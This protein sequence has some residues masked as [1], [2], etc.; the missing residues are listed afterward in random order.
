MGLNA[1]RFI[2]VVALLLVFSSSIFVMVNDI[3][4]VNHFMAAKQ[5]G[6]A[7][8][9]NCDYIENS[10]VPNQAAGVF[11]AILNRLL[12]ILE[13]ITLLLAELPPAF[14]QTFFISY[15]PVLGPAFGLGALGI[16]QGLIGATILSHHVDDFTLVAAFF[17]FSVGCLNMFLGLIFRE[18]AKEKRSIR[19]WKGEKKSVLPTSLDQRPQFQN[20]PS[21]VHSVFSEKTLA[22]SDP[23]IFERSNSRGEGY[24]FGRQGE[25]AAGL[26]GFLISKPLESLPRY[27]AR[28]SS[29]HSAH[30][31]DGGSGDEEVYAPPRSKPGSRSHSR[32]GS[33]SSAGSSHYSQP[34]SRAVTPIPT[35]HSSPTAI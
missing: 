12:I 31:S 22:P 28:P 19:V 11:W 13:V 27:A 34:P 32:S 29:N 10:T 14:M 35:F 6:N 33:S 24:G 30:R 20:S 4:A 25:K 17:L 18:K 1:V 26:K 7:T 2:S 15:F 9:V 23:P 3:R 21:F 8:M 5:D 16:F